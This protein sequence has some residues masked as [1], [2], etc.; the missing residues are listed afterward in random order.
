[1]LTVKRIYFGNWLRDYSQAMDIA[2]LSKLPKQTI[3]NLVMALAFLAMGYGTGEF[4]VTEER[5]GV[6][7]PVEHI[8]SPK[9][10]AETVTTGP[11]ADIRV[12]QGYAAD[13]PGGDARKFDPRLRPPV[14]PRELEIDPRTG[15]KVRPREPVQSMC[16]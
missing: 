3:L 12:V 9:V 8:D 15:M 10:R 13:Q 2:G 4:E 11:D 7:L 14:D 5:L 1:M 6:Y 16:R